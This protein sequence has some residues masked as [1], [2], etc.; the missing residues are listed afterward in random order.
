MWPL[1][2]TLNFKLMQDASASLN[3]KN[4]IYYLWTSTFSCTWIHS[5]IFYPACVT[6][7]LWDLIITDKLMNDAVSWKTVIRHIAFEPTRVTVY[8]HV[9]FGLKTQH[10][11]LVYFMFE[12]SLTPFLSSPRLWQCWSVQV[13]LGLCDAAFSLTIPENQRSP[14]WGRLCVWG[15]QNARQLLGQWWEWP[16]TKQRPL[17]FWKGDAFLL[18]SSSRETD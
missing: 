3:G 18:F 14:P 17:H 9:H 6:C 12:A 2:L 13:P 11:E 16:L 7:V 10:S 15:C 5:C 1:Y 8:L 4:I